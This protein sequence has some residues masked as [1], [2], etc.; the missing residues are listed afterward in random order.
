LVRNGKVLEK[1]D[2]D[3]AL[4]LAARGLKMVAEEYGPDSVA[5]LVSPKTTNEDAYLA[6]KLARVAV[7]HQ[8]SG[9]HPAS[10]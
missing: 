5:V 7:G 10:A 6:Q 8:Q 9:Q 1:A 4:T 3:A 2:W